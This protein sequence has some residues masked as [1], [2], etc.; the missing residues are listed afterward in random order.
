MRASLLAGNRVAAVPDRSFPAHA[1]VASVV[2]AASKSA[3]IADRRKDWISRH[4]LLL[5]VITR[6]VR[7]VTCE[8]LDVS[9]VQDGAKH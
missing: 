1:N 5:E 8:R 9:L 3:D 4:D 7:V 6:Q 2:R